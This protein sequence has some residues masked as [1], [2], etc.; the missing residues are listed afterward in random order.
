MFS[1][2]LSVLFLQ[3]TAGFI[4]DE[5]DVDLI[6]RQGRRTIELG[7]FTD[8]GLWNEMKAKVGNNPRK[9]E[10]SIRRMVDNLVKKANP[11]FSEFG[12]TLRIKGLKVFKP[13]D[14][15]R[16]SFARQG[17]IDETRLKDFDGWSQRSNLKNRYDL[18]ALITD[19]RYSRTLGI[20]N[21]G[22]ICGSWSQLISG[23]KL[24]GRGRL[25]SGEMILVHEIGHSLGA[26][27]DGDVRHETGDCS[28][29][30]YN[31]MT[32][33]HSFKMKGWSKCSRRAIRKNKSSQTCLLN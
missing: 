12:I 27:H 11:H 16:Y 29:A 9:V 32:R 3:L 19:L 33:Y 5:K 22:T 25:S 21:T 7:I 8:V 2:A 26:Q 20:A 1:L 10:K 23:V 15:H 18:T 14:A 24:D 4:I 30:L 6:T 31:I 13:Q 17:E 28:P